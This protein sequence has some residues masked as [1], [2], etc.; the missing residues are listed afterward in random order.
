MNARK[1]PFG[2]SNAGMSVGFFECDF[3]CLFYLVDKM[4]L[5]W[6]NKHHRFPCRSGASGTTDTVDVTL[7]LTRNL[8]VHHK[9]NIIHVE[10]ACCNVRRHKNLTQ[11]LFEAVECSCALTL[12]EITIEVL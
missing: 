8:E 6:R 7:W 10:S 1:F 9:F 12:I 5:V 11:S 4:L 2:I 3:L